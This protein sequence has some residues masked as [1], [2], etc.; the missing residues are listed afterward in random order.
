MSLLIVDQ[1]NF[2]DYY[3]RPTMFIGVYYWTIIFW[4][5]LFIG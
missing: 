4:F 2:R 3:S 5:Y 1:F